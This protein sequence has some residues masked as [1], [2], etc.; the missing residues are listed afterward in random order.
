MRVPQF[1]TAPTTASLF[2]RLLHAIQAMPDG[3]RLDVQ[4]E[5]PTGDWLAVSF[6]D[7]GAGIP[8]ENLTKLF[9]PLFTTK[10][11]GIGLGLALTKTLVEGQG[12]T[13]E[14]S[15]EVGRGSTFTVRLPAGSKEQKTDG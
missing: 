9:E 5:A 15:S 4:S 7:S 11:R 6:S 2:D 13:I 14:V 3:G 12:G 1:S 10:A 8:Q